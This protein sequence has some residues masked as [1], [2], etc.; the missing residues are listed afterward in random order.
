MKD[1][2]FFSFNIQ[3]KLLK[4]CA[5]AW[6]PNAFTRRRLEYSTM[7]GAHEIAVI[8]CEKLVVDPIQCEADM[9]TTVD[10]SKKI[11]LAIDQQG[12]EVTLAPAQG[13][14]LALAVGEVSYPTDKLP[15]GPIF[16]MSRSHRRRHSF[17]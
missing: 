13:K 5:D 10:I 6:A 14:F 11:P 12:F 7:V 9:G 15:L 4:R 3:D 2:Y 16:N 17:K 1:E 8:D